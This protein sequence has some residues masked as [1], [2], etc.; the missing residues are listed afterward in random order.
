MRE[1]VRTVKACD[2][3]S[4]QNCGPAEMGLKQCHKPS[5]NLGM[6]KIHVYTTYGA[7]GDGFKVCFT[8]IKWGLELEKLIMASNFGGQSYDP[9]KI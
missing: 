2:S 5:R 8:N 7:I 9:P 3:G 1:R 4:G 6:V